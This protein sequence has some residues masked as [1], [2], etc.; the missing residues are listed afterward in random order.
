MRIF[1]CLAALVAAT[2]T[3]GVE[4][5]EY[6]YTFLTVGEKS[7]A[8]SVSYDGAGHVA[9]EFEFNDRG[10]G[11]KTTTMLELNADGIPVKIDIGGNNY[12]KGEVSEHFAIDGETATWNSKIENGSTGWDGRAFFMPNNAAPELMAILARA[13]LATESGSLPLLP[14]GTA[15]IAELAK[16][17]LVNDGAGTNITLYGIKGLDSSPSYVWLHDDGRFFG[18]DYGWVGITPEGF[19]SGPIISGDSFDDSPKALVQSWRR[20]WKKRRR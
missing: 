19:E 3:F 9:I 6:R 5:G 17:T 7:G 16:R 12:Y 14:S 13:L 4:S 1:L 11:P 18:V 10:R 8:Q 2:N 20:K 15:S